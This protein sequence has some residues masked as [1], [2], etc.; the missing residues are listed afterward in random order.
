MFFAVSSGG[1][2]ADTGSQERQQAYFHFSC[3]TLL[4]GGEKRSE[5]PAVC[6]KR[7]TVDVTWRRG[8][9]SCHGGPCQ[10]IQLL[11]RWR[12]E[13]PC[14]WD[15]PAR[16]KET[17]TQQKRKPLGW[18]S[19]VPALGSHV[20]GFGFPPWEGSTTE[21]RVALRVRKAGPG[22]TAWSPEFW[23]GEVGGSRVWVS[24]G[25]L[26]RARHCLKTEE[27]SPEP[28]RS[29]KALGSVLGTQQEK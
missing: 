21:A 9:Q 13:K 17:L 4:E 7:L 25:C 10:E 1:R 23:N 5:A 19:R 14:I 16:L 2:G 28:S 15:Q 12:Q 11:G 6:L 20:W 22:C 3:G 29:V 8:S 27:I 24:L 18:T 26:D